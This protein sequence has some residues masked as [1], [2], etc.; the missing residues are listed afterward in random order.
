M[1]KRAGNRHRI[2]RLLAPA[3]RLRAP[4]IRIGIGVLLILLGF[5]VS[6]KSILFPALL[7]LSNAWYGALTRSG[8]D[9]PPTVITHYLGGL[10]LCVGV[11]LI[12]NGI[13]IASRR[14]MED[15]GYTAN[16]GTTATGAAVNV[17][18]RRRQLADGPRVVAIGG[19][20]GLSTLLRGLKEHTSNI[21]AIVTV[22]DDGGSSGRL[23]QEMGILPPGDLRNCLVALADAERRM[24]DLFQHRFRDDAG[25]LSGHSIGN[26]L[27]A[28]L[29]DQAGGDVDKAL[30]VASQV[31]NIRGRVVP[32]TTRSVRL[33]ALMEDGSEIYGETNIVANPQQIRRLYLDPKNVEP[34]PAALEAIAE[35]DLIITG[36]G[37]VY[38]SVIP[39]LLV[40]QIASTIAHTEAVKVYVC[41]V[42]TQRGESDAF[43]A[44]EHILAIQAN[45]DFRICDFVLANTGV[46]SPA[47]L[48]RYANSDQALVVADLERIHRMGFSP[49]TADL[50]SETDFVR[51][52]PHRTAERVMQLLYR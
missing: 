50:M 19:G 18:V 49:I 27:L 28:A 22:T 41:N 39:N 14:L 17:W 25:S 11:F 32:S 12:I 44:A 4:I 10:I 7:N 46:P 9:T 20:T 21:T 2:K 6:F 52:D 24:T 1:A 38:T 5:I 26:L 23:V 30:N 45:V 29:I 3:T 35:A 47:A 37:S 8:L 13:R 43:T 36:P 34:H 40:P 33:R 15:F 16:V 51:H 42:M 48:E 31:L